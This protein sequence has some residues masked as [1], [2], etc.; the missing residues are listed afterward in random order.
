MHEATFTPL[1]SASGALVV[2]A[3]IAQVCFLPES[4]TIRTHL[5]KIT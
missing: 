2:E 1:I 4:N 3:G 5:V